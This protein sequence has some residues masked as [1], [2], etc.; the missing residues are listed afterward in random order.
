MIIE[1]DL[2][3]MSDRDS[4][5]LAKWPFLFEVVEWSEQLRS[6][7]SAWLGTVSCSVQT[8][9]CTSGCKSEIAGIISPPRGLLLSELLVHMTNFYNVFEG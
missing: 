4:P 5:K 2:E 9:L 3:F 1:S 6:V 8:Q 7:T